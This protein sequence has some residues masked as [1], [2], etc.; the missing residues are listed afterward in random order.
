M[1]MMKQ[2]LRLASVVAPIPHVVVCLADEQMI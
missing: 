2:I 1:G